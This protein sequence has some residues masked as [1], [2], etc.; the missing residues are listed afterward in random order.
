[1]KLCVVAAFLALCLTRGVDAEILHG[2]QPLSEFGEIKESFPNGRFQ[3]VKAAWVK[4]E[5]AFYSMTGDGFP[6]TLY[7]LFDDERPF[8]R[9][10]LESLSAD[11]PEDTASEVSEKTFTRNLVK[12][13][14]TQSE[15]RALT[16]RWVRW[17]P[18]APIPMERVKAKYGE[19]SKCDFDPADFAPFCSWDS[20]LL[21][22]QTT[23]NRRFAL[24]L[25]ASFTKGELR[26]AYRAKGRAIPPWLK[27]DAP[28][29]P[30][31]SRKTPAL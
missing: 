10:Y 17:V 2:V 22:V 15:E 14:A 27:D 30:V 13:K 24:F 1:M 4:E 18:A 8:W 6:G 7:L 20:R 11:A 9:E 29:A 5:E 12:E 16:I 21:S 31:K 26:A 25:T 19:P 3:R 28:A 23:E